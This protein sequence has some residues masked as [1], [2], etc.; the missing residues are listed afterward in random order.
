[1]IVAGVA[2]L[3]GTMDASDLA[4]IEASERDILQEGRPRGGGQPA[5]NAIVGTF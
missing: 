1:M 5:L 2:I 4:E 3:R